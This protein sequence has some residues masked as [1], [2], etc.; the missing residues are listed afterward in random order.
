MSRKLN[1]WLD[2]YVEYARDNYCP[3]SFHLWTGLSVL[4]AALERKVWL[5][6]GKII[7]YPNIYTMLV[8]YAGVGKSTALE[9]GVDLLERI[10]LEVNPEIKLIAEQIT[11]PG[12]VKDM[13]IRQEFALT[14]TKRVFHSSGFFVAS[15]ASASA[16]QNTHGTFTSTITRFYDCPKVFRKVTKGEHDKPTEIYNV[17]FNMLC[18]ATFDYLKTL[19][20]ESSVMGGFASRVIYVVNKERL[21]R[22]PKWG[23]SDHT[24][25]A[26][27]EALFLDLCA[28]HKLIGRFRPTPGFVAAWEKFQP[29]S[30]RRLAEMKSPRLESLAARTSTNTTKIAMLLAVA[31]AD[32]LVLDV[33]HWDRAIALVDEV[34]RD[35][36]FVLS[37]GAMADKQSQSGVTQAVGQTLK[38]NG[39]AL[40]MATLKCIVLANGNNVEAIAK[41]IDFML[42]A[43]W[44]STD[45]SGVVKLLVDPD[46]YL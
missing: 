38:R 30:D 23:Q 4:A 37:Q 44:I 28:I 36:A 9:R 7:F 26:A 1:N 39:G 8:T 12:L 14:E 11:E 27:Q 45:S 34:S 10:K 17:C 42:G 5:V 22:E 6:N 25:E 43:E 18:G 3:D 32:D 24:D 35:N 19:V 21:I 46:R 16:L 13:E 29:E 33:R 40:P 41:T 2:S 15:E 20:N 31:E